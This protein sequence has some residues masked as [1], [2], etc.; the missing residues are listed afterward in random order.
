[1]SNLIIATNNGTS[2]LLE[3]K[4]NGLTINHLNEKD[5]LVRRDRIDEGDLV[6]VINWYNYQK[7]NGNEKLNF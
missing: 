4:E 6:T 1:M 7:E 2:L 3:L 5:E